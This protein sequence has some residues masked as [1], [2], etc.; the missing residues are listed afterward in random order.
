VLQLVVAE[1]PP[2]AFGI[3]VIVTGALIV[4]TFVICFQR[5]R[6]QSWSNP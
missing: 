4:T 1:E 3:A 2:R 6:A 5:R